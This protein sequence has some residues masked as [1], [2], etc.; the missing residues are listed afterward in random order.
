MGLLTP[1]CVELTGE[2]KIAV[3]DVVA[4]G[5]PVFGNSV[6]HLI[7]LDHFVTGN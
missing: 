1:L 5:I 6:C 7:G 4:S 2:L 3:G